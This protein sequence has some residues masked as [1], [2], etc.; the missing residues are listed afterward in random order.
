MSFVYSFVVNTPINGV[1]QVSSDLPTYTSST[2]N[3][4]TYHGGV[5][6]IVISFASSLSTTEI[7]N[8]TNYFSTFVN[9]TSLTTFAYSVSIPVTTD[10]ILTLGYTKAGSFFYKVPADSSF[11]NSIDILPVPSKI[12][13]VTDRYSIRLFDLTNNV[14]LFELTNQDPKVP[15][16]ASKLIANRVSKV[17]RQLCTI[18]I[19]LCVNNILLGV[20]VDCLNL[21]FCA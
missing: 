4:I 16:R 3:N 14:I 19:H 8:I 20:S 21:I 18:E 17:P 7:Q 10:S 13:L 15:I 9:N 5:N 12:P 6:A 1:S 11:W 2:I